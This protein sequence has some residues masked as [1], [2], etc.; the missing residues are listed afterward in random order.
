MNVLQTILLIKKNE[1]SRRAFNIRCE[2]AR[3]YSLEKLQTE[4]L[5]T[6]EAEAYKNLA[7]SVN[8]H[9]ILFLLLSP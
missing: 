3:P 8:Y 1:Q 7:S 4:V 6:R 2:V 9:P 5:K